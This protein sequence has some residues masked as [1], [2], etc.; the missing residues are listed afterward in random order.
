[1]KFSLFLI[2]C[3]A[4]SINCYVDNTNQITINKN[5]FYTLH[6]SI[7]DLN[8]NNDEESNFTFDKINTINTSSFKLSTEHFEAYVHNENISYQSCLDVLEVFEDT[9]DTLLEY[10][11]KQPLYEKNRTKYRVF[12][13]EENNPGVVASTYGSGINKERSG[14]IIFF[15][16][17]SYYSDLDS[18]IVHEY[19]H[20]VQYSYNSDIY[21]IKWFMESFATWA[22]LRFSNSLSSPEY[23]I[24]K[25]IDDLTDTSINVN[26]DSHSPYYKLVLP[27]AI[28]TLYGINTIIKI[29]EATNRL[30]GDCDDDDIFDAINEGIS[31]SGKTG[32]M[33][34]IMAEVSK[35]IININE[36]C[37]NIKDINVSYSYFINNAPIINYSTSS[38]TSLEI[39]VNGYSTKYVK[40]DSNNFGTHN[41][42]AIVTSDYIDNFSIF[43]YTY[44]Q[45]NNDV[46][47]YMISNN[48][49]NYLYFY[50]YND[51]SNTILAISNGTSESSTVTMNFELYENHSF[52]D[53]YCTY[54]KEYTSMHSWHD[55]FIW[56]SN[57]KHI[58]TC[59]C[60]ETTQLSHA[61]MANDTGFPFKTCI[62]CGGR[63]TIGITQATFS[64]NNKHSKNGSYI[65]DNGV[66]VLVEDDVDAYLKNELQFI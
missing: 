3:L 40:L 9:Y 1:M 45:N 6:N 53:H 30:N 22:S 60:G 63:A 55:P 24:K 49:Y 26:L 66:V 19:F 47:T 57:T 8:D 15:N 56:V 12:L 25:Y 44:F 59:N 29:C 39:E 5:N 31:N 23:R 4:L 37:S 13:T 7:N 43:N 51:P 38:N 58:S 50:N 33:K 18:T 35:I 48:S 2:S 62:Q 61:I 64:L 32:T 65:L 28:D 16:F 41:F 10:G 21:K 54:C 27:L 46:Q 34:E 42:R 20:L 52:L 36:N 14:Y 11:F 17:T